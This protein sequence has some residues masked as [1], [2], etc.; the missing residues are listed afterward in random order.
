[1]IFNQKED[2]S[3]DIEFTKEELKI[4]AEHKKIFLPAEGLRHFGN[5][6]VKIVGDW[7][8]NFNENVKELLTDDKTVVKGQKPKDTDD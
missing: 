3:C 5:A 4:I 1:M 7:N 6:L 2:G 8:M